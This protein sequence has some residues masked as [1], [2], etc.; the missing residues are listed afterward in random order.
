MD[1]ELHCLAEER[2]ALPL[3]TRQTVS[4]ADAKAY[5]EAC[6]KAEKPRRPYPRATVN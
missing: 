2:W 6:A 5:L 1:E 3:Q 4:W